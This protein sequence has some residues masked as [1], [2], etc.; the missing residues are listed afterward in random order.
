MPTFLLIRHGENDFVRTGKMAG[1]T[2]GVHLNEK[3]QKQASEL[4][5]A[6]KTVPLAAVYSSPLERAVETAEPIASARGLVVQRLPGLMETDI[7]DWQGLEIKK[8]GKLPAWKIVQRAPSRFRFP[9]GDSFVEQQTRLVGEVERL[10][11][12]HKPEELLALVFHADP[13]KLLL[14]YYLGMPLDFFQRLACS[15][16]SVS[17]LT[18]SESGAIVH[19]INILPP[20][21]LPQP[22]R[23]P[24]RRKST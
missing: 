3:G 17:I 5:E 19:K 13:I 12:G 20:F 15:P 14:A 6:L 18:L 7:G 10:V 1:R 11:A 24:A 9:G 22:P 4:A 23:R 2:P 8:I 16:G 21:S